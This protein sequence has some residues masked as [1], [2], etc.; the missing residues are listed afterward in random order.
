MF[1]FCL[2]IQAFLAGQPGPPI[3][4]GD[5]DR[6]PVMNRF[7]HIVGLGGDEA[8]RAPDT[9]IGGFPR[10]PE[11]GHG[12]EFVGSER[13]V[14]RLFGLAFQFPFIKPTGRNEAAPFPV[15]VPEIRFLAQGFD[16]GIDR[17][18]GGLGIFDPMWQKSPIEKVQDC[19]RAFK[20]DH[21]CALNFDQ[22]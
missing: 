14:E 15:G 17:A 19:R 1:G 16:P 22:G 12:H 3:R 5:E 10:F 20:F 18:G 4:R 2:V 13:E 21:L 6:H 9:A 8:H 7:H 11:A